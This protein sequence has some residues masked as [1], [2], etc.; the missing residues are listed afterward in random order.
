MS[1]GRGRP[2]LYTPEIAAEICTRLADGETLRSICRADHMPDERTV[3]GWALDAKSEFF[4]HYKKAR[5]LGYHGMADDLV[6]IADDGTN[7]YVE[8]ERQDG[9]KHVVFDGEHVQRS[10][11]RVDTRKWLL[12]KALPKVYGDKLETTTRHVDAE[13]ND[14]APTQIDVARAIAFAFAAATANPGAPA[15]APT[16]H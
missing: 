13:G 8:R 1:D 3:R 15:P 16:Q 14:I 10:R 7:D 2:S 11:L 6:D 12:S 5:L 9:T 4:P